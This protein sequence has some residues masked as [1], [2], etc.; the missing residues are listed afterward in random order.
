MNKLQAIFFRAFIFLVLLVTIIFNPFGA[1]P[2]EIFK[3]SYLSVFISIISI[4][5][6]FS[7]IFQKKSKFFY[8]KT[9]FLLLAFFLF[10]LIISTVF[11]VAPNLSFFGSYSRMQGVYSHLIYALFFIVSLQFFQ[12]KKDQEV[13]FKFLLGFSVLISLHAILQKF[14]MLTF[15]QGAVDM[16]LGRSFSTFGHPNFLGQFLIFPIFISLYFVIEKKKI[17]PFMIF[18]FNFLALLTTE[19]RASI[20]GVLAG[21]FLL[22]LLSKKISKKLKVTMVISLFVFFAL[23]ILFFASSLRSLSTRFLLW[24]ASIKLIPQYF[25]VGSGP[26]TFKLV[27]QKVADPQFFYLEQVYSVADRSHNEFLDLF[28]MQG[29]VGVFSLFSIFYFSLKRI[30]KKHLLKDNLVKTLVLMFF[31]YFVSMMFGFSLTV[32]YFLIYV[33]ASFLAINIFK[34]KTLKI[35]KSFLNFL[36]S[37]IFIVLLS[38]NLFHAMSLVQADNLYKFGTDK[39]YQN[40]FLVGVGEL[41]KAVRLNPFQDEIYYH[42]SDV[43]FLMGKSIKDELIL[44]KALQYSELAGNFNGKDF[45]YHFSKARIF[46]Y[47]EDYQ[48]AEQSYEMAV[49]KAP[50]NPVIL[51]EWGAMYYLSENYEKAIEV[52]EEVLALIPDYWKD[53]NNLDQLSFEESEKYRIFMKHMPDLWIVFTYLS[54]SYAEIGDIETAEYYFQFIDEQDQ[55]D[56]V[57]RIIE[58]NS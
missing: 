48:K 8:N 13:F 29:L 33:F 38:F 2:F 34:F 18:I 55:K 19:N 37:G 36:L 1:N 41:E 4:I 47:L 56:K 14:G 58:N 52:L 25:I 49:S 35:R 10:S 6:V 7:F 44:N 20:L 16:F 17:F 3:L 31:A 28:I 32:H 40:D 11:S 57:R 30:F 54:R 15:S 22:V 27:F 50:I 42:L 53:K 46:T 39:V 45:R 21:I 26:E 23:F 51:K 5:L 43:F 12:K 24:L 9:T